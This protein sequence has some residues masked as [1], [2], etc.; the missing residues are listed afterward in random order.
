MPNKISPKKLMSSKWTKLLVSNKE[1]HFVVSSVEFDDEQNV[2]ECLIQAV[3]SKN[4][5]SINWRELT[6]DQQWKMGWK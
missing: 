3:M 5:Y 6:D 2:V 1:K 4:E